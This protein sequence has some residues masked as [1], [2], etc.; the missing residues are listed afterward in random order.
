LSTTWP[1]LDSNSGR[2]GGKPTNNRLSYGT[3]SCK[4]LIRDCAVRSHYLTQWGVDLLAPN[5][6]TLRYSSSPIC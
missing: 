5:L 4:D 3:A 1:D 2:R 6:W